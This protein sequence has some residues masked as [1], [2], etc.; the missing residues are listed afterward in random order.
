MIAYA[1]SRRV[2]AMLDGLI[3][4]LVHNNGCCP[5]LYCPCASSPKGN[6]FI[7]ESGSEQEKGQFF[8]GPAVDDHSNG[9]MNT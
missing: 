8:V 3:A 7:F 1:G 6:Y 9:F 5:L 2:S 4:E